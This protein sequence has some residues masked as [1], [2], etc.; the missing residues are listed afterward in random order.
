VSDSTLKQ[1][2]TDLA[3]AVSK[4]SEGVRSVLETQAGQIGDLVAGVQTGG[5][6]TRD[7]SLLWLALAGLGLFAVFIFKK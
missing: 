7:K 5:D 6:T 2:T 1:I 4:S 3:S